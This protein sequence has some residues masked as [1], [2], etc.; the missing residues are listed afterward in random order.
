MIRS[1]LA[2]L[3]LLAAPQEENEAERLFKKMEQKLLAAKSIQLKYGAFRGDC[4]GRL[5]LAEGNKALIEVNE[6]S[7]RRKLVSDGTTTA[8]VVPPAKPAVAKTPAHQ[9]SNLVHALTRF[10]L[11]TGFNTGVAS[12]WVM[13]GEEV[14]KKVELKDFK[15][16]EKKKLEDREV[17]KIEFL[18]TYPLFGDIKETEIVI[19]W[20]D[21]GS[22]L[23]FMRRIEKE[24]GKGWEET[25]AEFK[26]DEKVDP[27]E[28]V[29]PDR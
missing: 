7:F 27:K 18:R 5:L 22:S 15:L 26:L 16:L 21:A 20:I 25:F 29:V 11:Y 28:F 1:S 19:L 3:M 17:H 2:V 4:T 14:R 9:Y 10:D 12:S 24:R 8:D 23:P 13:E 6:K